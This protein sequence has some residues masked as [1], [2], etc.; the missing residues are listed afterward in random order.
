MADIKDPRKMHK[1][2][3]KM[4]EK[5]IDLL[6]SQGLRTEDLA[7]DLKGSPVHI[8][9]VNF[10]VP[11]EHKIR[12]KTGP[13]PYAVRAKYIEDL[14]ESLEADLSDQWKTLAQT[15]RDFIFRT[16]RV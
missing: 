14:I 4:G 11:L 12:A 7:E 10:D 3:E 9:Q 5:F 8:P 15:Y 16:A 13:P 6:I 2:Y 1:L